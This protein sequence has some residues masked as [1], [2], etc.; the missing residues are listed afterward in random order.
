[1]KPERWQKIRDVLEKALELA[2][3]LRTAFLDGTCSSDP[4]L[5]NE[6][7]ALLVSGDD[8]SAGFLQSSALADG[9]GAEMDGI[10]SAGAL[11]AGQV[12]VQRFM[13]I[14][15]LGEG[16]MG[17]VWLAEQTWP[18]RRQV[19]LKLIK[20]GMYDETIVQRFQAERQSLAIMDHPAIAKVFDA[21]T[22]PQGQPYFVMEYVPG[23]PITEYS[24][25]K[26]LRISDRL[27]LFIQACEGVQH[28]HQKAIIHRDL[29]PAN[30][31]V[32]EVDGKPVLR[33]IDFGLAKATTPQVGSEPL[34]TQSGHFV[35]TPGYMSPEQ[36]D[37]N[38][39]DIDTRT[40]V[41]SL[42]VVL[43]VL[44]CGSQPFESPQRQKQSLEELL[45]RIREEDPPRPSTKVVLDRDSSARIAEASGTE[46]K[47]LA[48]DLRG[49]LDSIAMKALDKDLA[50]RYD[51]ASELAADI[52]RYLTHE[53]VVARPAS[54]A[55]RGGKFVK[56]HK[57]ALAIA[58]VFALVVVT[59]VVAIVRE[60]RIARIE[61]ARAE[62]HFES[63]RKLTNSMLFEFHDSIEALPGST[64]PR[65]LVVSRALEYLKQIDADS[66]NDPATLRDLAAGYERIGRIRAEE[67]HPH[68]GGAGSYQQANEL[69][70]KALVIR[71]RLAAADPGDPNLQLELL[72][73]MLNVARIDEQF[74]ELDRALA[75]QQQRLEIEE[76]LA[77]THDSDDLQYNIAASLIGI[78][79]LKLWLG[80]YESALDYERRSLIMNQALLD[81]NP[82][83][84][85]MLRG[86]WR[87]RG[88]TAMVLRYDKKF[89][90][91]A[92]ESRKAL[93]IS[94]QLAARDPNNSDFQRFL[95]ADN[96]SL[97][98]CLAYSGSFSEVPKLCQKAITINQAMVKADKSNVQASADL[99]NSTMT[100]GLVLYLMHEPREALLFERRADAMYHDVAAHEPDSQANG[101]DHAES[102]IY[103]GRAEADLHRPGQARKDLEQAK[104]VME[105][106]VTRSP[107]HKYFRDTLDE[108]TAALKAL[109]N[110]TASIAVH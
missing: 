37:P 65:E 48:R 26:K 43:Y 106:L 99:A 47:Q 22:T 110:D 104:Q 11:E 87:S 72:G 46:P 63:L 80:E 28:A 49:D 67:G 76:Q 13:L 101:V 73:T 91:G 53:P 8:M 29:K 17:Q 86:V 10:G 69:Y 60:A 15:K 105:Q 7:E 35:G 98:E 12:F 20:A 93:A 16:G 45:R 44:L 59:G 97:C 40:D 36:A 95:I 100:M 61:Q 103:A 6:V 25:Q 14:S 4:L 54:A 109:P 55:Y 38:V 89:T 66:P 83:S 33:I 34:H 108:A 21:G 27:E 3:G 90:E 18:V 88:W 81:R 50:R 31:L 75:L 52:R 64:A 96:Q 56:R 1:M 94:E 24:D 41:Y 85:K 71:Q 42:G 39:L 58:T 79:E 9:L 77:K 23:L 102:L 84:L 62:Q 107:K 2:P 68:L 51:G 92:A 78:G 82:G 5:R 70:E 74:G 32:A 30:I 57:L 19:A